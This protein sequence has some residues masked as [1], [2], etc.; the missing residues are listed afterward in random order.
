MV[1]DTSGS[2]R[3]VGA[4]GRHVN[5]QPGCGVAD[6]VHYCIQAISRCSIPRHTTPE[7]EIITTNDDSLDHEVLRARFEDALA[8]HEPEFE[9]F[10]LLRFF[11]LSVS[12]GPETCRV[13][14]PV[15]RSMFNP[16]DSLH[17]GVIVLAL[18]VS[19]GH[20]LRNEGK[21]GVTVEL[22][23]NFLRA[24]RGPAYAQARIL[25]AGRRVAHV[26]SDLYDADDRLC[27]SATATFLRVDAPR[28][29]GSG[30]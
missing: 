26:A 4:S 30:A 12:Y 17:G 25:R 28:P 6:T 21:Q 1:G 27:A 15:D 3:G 9:R 18:D 24:V 29:G 5:L 20:L 19:M 7:V 16:Q 8:H 22:H 13:D 11:G 23:T 14:I 2:G 10:F